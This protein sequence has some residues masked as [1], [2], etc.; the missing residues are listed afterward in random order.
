MLALDMIRESRVGSV[1]QGISEIPQTEQPVNFV[2]LGST[3]LQEL[4]ME[5]PTHVPLEPTV[6]LVQTIPLTVPQDTEERNYGLKVT[7]TVMAVRPE[8]T[9]TLRLPLTVNLVAAPPTPQETAPSVHASASTGP[10]R[11]LWAPVCV[12]QGISITMRRTLSRRRRTATRT[13][14]RS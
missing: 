7:M 4:G 12:C 9:V 3:V 2:P 6:P 10:S 11:S 5:T 1:L 8:P 13:V 14:N